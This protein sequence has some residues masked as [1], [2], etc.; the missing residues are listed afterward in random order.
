MS[1]IVFFITIVSLVVQGTTVSFMADKLKL[2]EPLPKTGN[3]FG[4]E[5]PE[6]I[7]TDLTDMTVT[8][9]SLERGNTLKEMQLPKGKLV[10]LVKR[11]DEYL[12]PDGSLT[13][14]EG[15]KLLVI[16]DKKNED[17]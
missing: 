17:D 5:L 14:H 1:N 3:E 8:A 16:S 4:V 7:N 13:L 12:I 9:E 11:D 15:D 6:E 10:I 2:S